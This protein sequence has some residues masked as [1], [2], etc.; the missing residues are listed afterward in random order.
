M[1]NKK[2]KQNDHKSLEN[3][4]CKEHFLY[5]EVLLDKENS[6]HEANSAGPDDKEI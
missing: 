4:D 3:T 6:A 2:C 1:Y 5:S